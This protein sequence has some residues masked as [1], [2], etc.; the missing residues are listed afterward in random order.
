[1]SKQLLQKWGYINSALPWKRTGSQ[2]E[3]KAKFKEEVEQE[4]M[5]IRRL[6]LCLI[7]LVSSALVTV[8]YKNFDKELNSSMKIFRKDLNAFMK[9]EQ[10]FRKEI[11]NLDKRLA[12]RNIK[13][14]AY[15]YLRCRKYVAKRQPRKIAGVT[16][17]LI[18]K[19]E[20][21]EEADYYGQLRILLATS[22][23][24]SLVEVSSVMNKARQPGMGSEICHIA[25]MRLA[26]G[27]VRA[28]HNPILAS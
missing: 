25:N 23:K 24:V 7:L 3:A 4:V 10:I 20:R 6:L 2:A 9:Q 16:R 11:V 12:M 1:M 22:K 13:T 14:S 8:T 21:F 18:V 28:W 26:R 5:D 19:E 15:Q 27:K 17:K